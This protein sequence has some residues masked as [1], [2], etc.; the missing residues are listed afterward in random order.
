MK[1]V[2]DL[3]EAISA[4]QRS[5]LEAWV[6]DELV[7]PQQEAGTLLFPDIECARVRLICTL[8]YELEIDLET[9]PVVL[10][11]VDQLYDARQHL[12]SLTAAVVVQ[13]KAIQAK[14]IAAMELN[15]RS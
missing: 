8:H 10:S 11:L 2:D 1:R 12:M 4:L 6:R 7:T 9:L 14:I 5:D 15:D 13:D 3:V